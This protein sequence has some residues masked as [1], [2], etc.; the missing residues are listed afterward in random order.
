MLDTR[1]AWVDMETS[2]GPTV[3]E[4]WMDIAVKWEEDARNPN[5]FESKQSDEKTLKEV[6]RYLAEIT[7][8][9][10][11][12]LRVRGDMHDT[13]M[14]SMGLK[15]EEQQCIYFLNVVHR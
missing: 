6:R 14:L 13:E 15:L 11:E 1:E 9:D 2:M 5:P 3:I 12:H 8:E 10:V 4:A 7:A